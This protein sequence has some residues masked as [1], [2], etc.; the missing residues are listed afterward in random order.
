M[1]GYVLADKVLAPVANATI[2]DHKCV[3]DPRNGDIYC[4]TYSNGVKIYV[5]YSKEN[6][7]APEGLVPAL[8]VAVVNNGSSEAVKVG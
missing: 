8:G 2:V 4:T 1:K 7:A 5:N 3:D 6:Y